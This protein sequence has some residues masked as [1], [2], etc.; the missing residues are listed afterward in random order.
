MQWGKAKNI[1]WRL[2]LA[3]SFIV[4]MVVLSGAGNQ[5]T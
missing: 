1:A 3:A 2:V 5:W 4:S